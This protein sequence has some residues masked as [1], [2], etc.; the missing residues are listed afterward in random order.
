MNRDAIAYLSGSDELPENSLPGEL[1]LVHTVVDQGDDGRPGLGE[2]LDWIDSGRAATLLVPRLGTVASSLGELIRLLDWLA[3]RGAGLVVLDLGWDTEQRAGRLTTSVLREVRRLTHD[4]EHPHRPPGRPGL[5]SISPE[6][7]ERIG[8]LRGRGLSLQAIADTLNAEGVPTP[9]GGVR[10]R[11]SS[12]QTALGY[13]RP[14]PPARPGP[15]RTPGPGGPAGPGGHP[16]PH[17][18]PRR[19]HPR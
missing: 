7:A 1:N 17:P 2:A 19:G 14:R 13:Q 18:G 5:Q 11:P 10:W 4:R 15:A 3:E 8:A 6:L 12:V 9:R 16:R